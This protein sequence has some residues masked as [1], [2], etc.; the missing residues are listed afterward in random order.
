MTNVLYFNQVS[1]EGVLP[2][3]LDL[4]KDGQNFFILPDCLKVLESV[5]DFP[6]ITEVNRALIDSGRLIRDGKP[7]VKPRSLLKEFSVVNQGPERVLCHMTAGDF[8]PTICH[9]K[10]LALVAHFKAH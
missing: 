7:L 9:L 4:V 3:F 6:G 8:R 1:I 10:N 5:Y 2:F